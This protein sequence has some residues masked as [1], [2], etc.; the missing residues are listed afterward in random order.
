MAAFT[1]LPASFLDL[2][3]LIASLAAMMDTFSPTEHFGYQEFLT[4]RSVAHHRL[5]SLPEWHDVNG[6]AVTS[7]LGAIYECSRLTAIAFSNAVLL[8]IPPSTGWATNFC[9]SLIIPLDRL[10]AY[11]C[12]TVLRVFLLWISILGGMISEADSL[13]H[14]YF[15]T[16]LRHISTGTASAT[17]TELSTTLDAF[18]WSNRVCDRGALRFREECGW[19]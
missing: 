15:K 14:E 5:L 4:V 19:K 16:L 2:L 10:R 9:S 13:H 12:S 18:M 1:N 8:G 3:Q 11:D 6:A 7:Q 17:S